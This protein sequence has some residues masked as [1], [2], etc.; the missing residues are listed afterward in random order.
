MDVLLELLLELVLVLLL[1]L[2]QYVFIMYQGTP[3]AIQQQSM[4]HRVAQV[5][6]LHPRCSTHG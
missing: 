1:L 3:V 2:L 5:I 4:A 6:W